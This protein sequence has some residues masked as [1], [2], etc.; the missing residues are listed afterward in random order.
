MHWPG[1]GFQMGTAI[2][3][4]K[5]GGAVSAYCTQMGKSVQLGGIE[6]DG[7]TSIGNYRCI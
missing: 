5:A 3:S 1:T 7:S 6:R 4:T 2:P